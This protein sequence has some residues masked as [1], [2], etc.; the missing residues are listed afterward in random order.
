MIVLRGIQEDNR[1][2]LPV[3]HTTEPQ[4]HACNESMYNK[5]METLGSATSVQTVINRE[6][7][8]EDRRADKFKNPVKQIFSTVMNTIE[9]KESLTHRAM[10]M[11]RS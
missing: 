10:I 5:L 6:E 7:V 9:R 1:D 3:T 11:I 4:R 2:F 8:R